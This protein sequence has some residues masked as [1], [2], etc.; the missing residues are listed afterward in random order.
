M[1]ATRRRTENGLTL[2]EL[3][4][5]LVIIGIIAALVIPQLIMSYQKAQQKKTIAGMRN[6]ALAMGL[7]RVDHEFLPDA[8][9][10]QEAVNIL[11]T[12]QGKMIG[13]PDHDAWGNE[14]YYHRDANTGYTLRCYGSDRVESAPASPDRRFDPADDLV[15]INGKFVAMPD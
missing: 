10:Y 3:L 7:Y 4:V 8:A 15:I 2:P 14:F 12:Y 6:F 9:T 11:R 1:R 5:V 13:A